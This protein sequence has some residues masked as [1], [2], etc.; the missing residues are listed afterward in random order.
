MMTNLRKQV[1]DVVF[2]NRQLAQLYYQLSFSH[3]VLPHWVGAEFYRKTSFWKLQPELCPC[4]LELMEFLQNN[5]VENKTV[6]HFGTGIHH[7][8]GLEN[9][10]LAVPNEV[11]GI[12]ASVPEYEEYM[13]LCLQNRG[14][15]KFYK[16]V[17]ADIY[18]L[19]ARCLPMLDI[20][21]LFHLGEFYMAEEAAFVHHDDESLVELFLSKLNPG[22]KVLFYKNSTGFGK[23][24][25]II[26]SFEEQGKMRQVEEYKHLLVY[27]AVQKFDFKSTEN[28]SLIYS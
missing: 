13:N 15:N 28:H 5:Q 7:I 8:L 9:H 25:K 16:V 6:F 22:G 2:G 3:P 18:T 19:T 4:D 10:K 26:K 14:L 1:R 20:V 12:T 27:G 21:S 17:F 11:I 24:E 23:A